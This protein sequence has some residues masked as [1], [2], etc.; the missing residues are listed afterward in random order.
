MLLRNSDLLHKMKDFLVFFD[1]LKFS[2]LPFGDKLDQ[3]EF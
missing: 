1:P 3:A 2:E